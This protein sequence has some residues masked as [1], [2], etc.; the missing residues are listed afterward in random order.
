MIIIISILADI[1]LIHKTEWQLCKYFRIFVYS[2][3][4]FDLYLI[5][6]RIVNL[7]IEREIGT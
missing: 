7:S 2:A 4:K 3:S 5:Y 1:D 6:H